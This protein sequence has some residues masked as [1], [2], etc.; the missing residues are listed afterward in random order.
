MPVLPHVTC[1]AVAAVPQRT[2]GHMGKCADTTMNKDELGKSLAQIAAQNSDLYRRI[3]MLCTFSAGLETQLRDCITQVEQ[4]HHVCE[5]DRLPP[6]RQYSGTV[7]HFDKLTQRHMDE[8]LLDVAQQLVSRL[9]VVGEKRNDIV[10]SSWNATSPVMYHQ[11]RV[12]PPEPL[13][14]LDDGLAATEQTDVVT[15]ETAEVIF[16]LECFRNEQRKFSIA[17]EVGGQRS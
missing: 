4:S 12:R 16:D 5:S 3:G 13:P 11:E 7:K 14:Q 15:E 6:H 2:S 17:A 1:G 10:H 8:S 9:Q